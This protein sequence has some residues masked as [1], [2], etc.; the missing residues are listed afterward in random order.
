MSLLFI[1]L[2]FIKVILGQNHPNA[3]LG[4]SWQV[5]VPE[6]GGGAVGKSLGMQTVHAALLPSGEVLVVSGS[7]N[8]NPG[9]TETFPDVNDPQPHRGLFQLENDPFRME[10]LDDY[11]Q[12]VNNVGV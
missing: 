6:L 7:S 2:F 10:K 8:R 12:L 11:F 4:G 5:V 3:L 9:S 1:T